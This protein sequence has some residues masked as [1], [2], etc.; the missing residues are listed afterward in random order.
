MSNM[1]RREPGYSRGPP[2][3]G[4]A[5]GGPSFYYSSRNPSAAP[6][7]SQ[8][9]YRSQHDPLPQQHQIHMHTPRGGP[10]RGVMD[11]RGSM[12]EQ[13]PSYFVE[14]LATF[15]VGRQFGLV[16]PADG[17]RKLKQME[18]SQAIWAQPM[19]LRLRRD[20][21]SVENE[22]GELVESFP[23]D[24]VEQ[25]TAHM[26]S[27]PRDA[28][29]NILLFVV[30]EDSKGRKHT[31][32][33]E[34]HIFQCN[35]VAA[36]EVAEDLQH[37]VR[38]QYKKVKNGRR[39][40]NGGNG[41]H[42]T[43]AY[44]GPQFGDD[45]SVS[46]EN[47]ELFER[48]VNTLNRCFDDIER[49]VARIQSAALAQRE[50][51]Q[52]AHRYR[53]TQRRDKQRA[54][55][56]DPHGILQMR[57]QLPLEAEFVEVLRKFKLSFN[58]LAKLRNH[59]H[60]P[61]A[62]ELVHFL[63]SPLNVILDASH[64]GLGRNIASLV[65]S[66]LLSL[67]ARELMQNCLTSKEM[68]VWLSL[69]DAWR[70]PPEDWPGPLPAPY[71]PVFMDG[72]TP[73]GPPEPRTSRGQD[74]T[75]HR[76]VSEPPAPY[77]NRERT[78]DTAPST[79]ATQRYN[80]QQKRA[81]QRNMSVDNL[82]IGRLSLEK[83]RLEFE[84]EKIR[85]RQ[86]RLEEEEQRVKV[87]RERLNKE[88]EMIQRERT[89]ST[90]GPPAFK[91]ESQRPSVQPSPQPERRGFDHGGM[92]VPLP[93]SLLNDP[94]QS[95][96]QRAFVQD[97][98]NRR[99]KLVQATYD[100]VAQNPKE[101]TVSRGE[102]LE[103]LNDSKNWWECKNMHNRGGYVPHTI[104]TVI[105]ADGTSP[106]IPNEE[107]YVG[108]PQSTGTM[109]NGNGGSSHQLNGY[110]S[111]HHHPNQPG[112]S[113]NQPPPRAAPRYIVDAGVQANV[114]ERV[115]MPPPQMQIPPPP[116]MANFQQQLAE[117]KLRPAP[118]RAPRLEEPETANDHDKAE[119]ALMADLIG[120]ISNAA[121]QKILPGSK[122][123]KS[124]VKLQEQ[125]DARGLQIWLQDKGFSVR[126]ME[127]LAEQDGATLFSLSKP[128][129]ERAAGREEGSRL[130]SQ[131]LVEKSRSNY[132]TKS[133]AELNAILKYRKTQVELS[134]EA[135]GEE[136][137]E[138]VPETE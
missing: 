103:V 97:I 113:P 71:K 65:V 17:I 26:S 99:C 134:N 129:L 75:I 135:A 94:D 45:V 130:Y 102:Y 44:G 2:S 12:E 132:Q 31:T 49:F 53:T 104:L 74:A 4:G 119:E 38:G 51:E 39:S 80:T 120:T 79:P 110:G 90:S 58:L 9:S 136:P 27:D 126:L 72:F 87:D 24:L 6:S 122:P 54:P 116:P 138:T 101:L 117:Q 89:N 114:H 124:N 73:Y 77:R 35:R 111:S 83:E 81:P 64:W 13:T 21:I 7:P 127:L 91:N 109:Y 50:L 128:A 78:V 88:A 25:P 70:T 48:D 55:P 30:K 125:T 10:S 56:P 86:R 32:P 33:T 52:Q 76:G 42:S 11:H 40:G 46:S 59:I 15:A 20:I 112:L 16:A 93:A 47:S 28:Y 105:P 92:S 34:M 68:D 69:G 43:H 22:N 23:L 133:R 95:P 121:G 61:N 37:Y 5:A 100:R 66:P 8:Y 19:V 106:A 123:M 131:L 18:R 1:I 137:K 63:F 107:I 36:T 96:R 67:D 85:E 115:P 118:Q 29:N 14:H 62:P 3:T 57:A 98:L 82:D 60:E 41:N 108:P 84:K